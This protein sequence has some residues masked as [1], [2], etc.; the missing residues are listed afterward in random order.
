MGLT[1]G[2][3]A[4]KLHVDLAAGKRSQLSLCRAVPIR[5]VK[6]CFGRFTGAAN[7][8]FEPQNATVQKRLLLHHNDQARTILA[9]RPI[10]GREWE[11]KARERE[12]ERERES[13]G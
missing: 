13:S 5:K 7:G 3:A 8:T 11:C 10:L 9:A 2:P 4:E 6:E 1:L 12:R